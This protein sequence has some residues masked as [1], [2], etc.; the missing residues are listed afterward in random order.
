[1]RMSPLL[2]AVVALA[3]SAPALAQ[4]WMPVTSREDG[5]RANFPGQ[6]KVETILTRRNSV[7]RCRPRLSRV[8]RAGPLYHDGRGLPR[9]ERL[10]NERA[11][12]C[13]A[14]KGANFSRTATPA[15]TTSCSKWPARWITRRGIISSATASRSRS[16]AS[17]SSSGDRPADAADQPGSVA[18]LRRV[19]QHAGRLYIHE[20]TVPVGHARAD[21]VHAVAGVGER[22][23]AG[24][25]LS[26]AVHRGLRRDGGSRI[27]SRRTRSGICD[28]S[29]DRPASRDKEVDHAV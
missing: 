24:D 29:Y 5:F 26:D 20:A 19:H 22:E 11:A 7:S 3:I 23:G 6:P 27:P 17:T 12:K 13:L 1:M 4:D 21:P 14:A 18:H 25:S 8:G 9:R 2:P 10:H 28:A 15:R 16:T